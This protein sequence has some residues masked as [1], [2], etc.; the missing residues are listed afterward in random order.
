[1]TADDAS[2]ETP[3]RAGRRATDPALGAEFSGSANRRPRPG[4]VARTEI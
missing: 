2:A 3:R 4:V 1:M